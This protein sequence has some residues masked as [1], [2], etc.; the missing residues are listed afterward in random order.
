MPAHRY[1]EENGLATLLAT[2]RSAGITQEVNLKEYVI[3]MPQ[4]SVNKAANSGFETQRRCHQKSKTGAPQKGLMPS[5]ILFLK[6]LSNS[7]NKCEL[8]PSMFQ[9][10][11]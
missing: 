4:P 10:A 5:K 2:K 6:K 9:N 3:C 7:K 11:L 1:I 8:F